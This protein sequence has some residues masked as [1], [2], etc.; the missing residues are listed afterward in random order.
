MKYSIR[1]VVQ[2]GEL[3]LKGSL[4]AA[5]LR[6]NLPLNVELIAL[7]PVPEMKW[8]KL[9][10]QTIKFLKSLSV[11]LVSIE[12]QWEDYP[13]GNKLYA[14]DEPTKADRK[15]FLDSDIFC[16]SDFLPALDAYDSVFIAKAADLATFG[17]DEKEWTLVESHTGISMLKERTSSTVSNESMPAYFNAGVVVADAKLPFGEGWR[18]VCWLID[19]LKDQIETRPWLDQI[20]L[21][22]TL[23]LLD[24]KPNFFGEDLNYP[25]HLKAIPANLPSL[26][27]YHWPDIVVKESRLIKIIAEL[28]GQYPLLGSILKSQDNWKGVYSEVAFY[29]EQRS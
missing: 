16:T 17:Q 9:N 3:E 7:V 27:H 1:F 5:S 19:E 2:S 12:N 21:P 13:I 22:F 15:I 18:K 25:A 8:G 14:F 20:G 6:N 11:K 23:S 28:V 26:I 24:L 29:L 10:K 4:L